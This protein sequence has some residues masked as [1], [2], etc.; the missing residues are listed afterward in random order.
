M[1]LR[2]LNS[3]LG[4]V[5]HFRKAK[6]KDRTNVTMYTVFL[7][8]RDSIEHSMDIFYKDVDKYENLPLVC[9]CAEIKKEFEEYKEWE[10]S[11]KIVNC[12]EKKIKRFR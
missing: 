4:N 8:G 3:E 9:Q 5:D 2:P 6:M 11:L 7:D 10:K 1:V 12:L